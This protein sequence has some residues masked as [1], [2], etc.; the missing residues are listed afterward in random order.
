MIFIVNTAFEQ[1]WHWLDLRVTA[2]LALP[3]ETMDPAEFAARLA[4]I[5]QMDGAA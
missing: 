5:G 4:E 3:F 1:T 2:L